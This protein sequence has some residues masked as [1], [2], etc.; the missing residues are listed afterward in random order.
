LALNRVKKDG[1]DDNSKERDDDDSS[2][3]R[4]QRH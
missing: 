2:G 1:Y 4:F 3:L